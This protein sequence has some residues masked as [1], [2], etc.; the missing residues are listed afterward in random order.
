MSAVPAADAGKGRLMTR[1]S[2][3]KDG[4]CSFCVAQAR[5]RELELRVAELTDISPT[6]E[7]RAAMPEGDR[8]RWPGVPPAVWA[9][10]DRARERVAELEAER[11]DYTAALRICTDALLDLGATDVLSSLVQYIGMPGDTTG[12]SDEEDRHA[13]E[14]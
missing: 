14:K 13:M 11:S 6:P 5:I 10:L 2:L 1:C 7:R 4:T 8:S 3:C 12:G 9:M